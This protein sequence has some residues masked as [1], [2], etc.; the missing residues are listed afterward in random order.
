MNDAIIINII[1]YCDDFPST[2]IYKTHEWEAAKDQ[3]SF[4]LQISQGQYSSSWGAG[5]I[6]QHSI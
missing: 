1:W 3:V 4:R 6:V 2:S 5:L